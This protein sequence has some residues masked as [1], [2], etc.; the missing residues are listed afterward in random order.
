LTKKEWDVLEEFPN[1]GLF[2]YTHSQTH[3]VLGSAFR[4][5]EEEIVL[6][7]TGVYFHIK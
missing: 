3:I 5:R 7:V 6:A 2:T 4:G 1:V